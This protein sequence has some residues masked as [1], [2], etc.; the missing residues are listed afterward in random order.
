MGDEEARRLD[1]RKFVKLAG[2]G[3][4]I[5][6]AGPLLNAG[7]ARAASG[8]PVRVGVL[9]PT[10]SSY[11]SMGR[12][13]S[14]GLALGFDAARTGASAVNATITQRDVA[15][16][17][18][19]AHAAA[20]ELL[21]GG[22]DVVVAGVSA[23][24]ARQLT[25][26]FEQ[27]KT[28]LVVANVGAHVV[29]PAARSAF[30][31]HNSLLYWQASYMMG[32]AATRAGKRAF[33]ASALP[34]AGYDTIYAF[35][36]G[37]EVAGGTI[38]GEGVSHA[39]PANPGVSELVAAVKSSGA[40]VLYG[41]YSGS[42]AAEFVQAAAG[43]GARL[44]VGSLG[45]ED[46]LLPSIGDSA[47]GALS[48]ASWT[49]T[50]TTPANQAFTGAFI[51]RFRRAPDPFAALG[52][53]TAALIAAGARQATK[54]G[55]A[56]KQFTDSL[57]GTS[58]EGPRGLMAIDAATNVVTGPLTIR[59]VQKTKRGLFNVDVAKLPAVSRFPDSLSALGGPTRSG[60]VN[61]YLC[62]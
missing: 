31:L 29:T 25:S 4:G 62:A 37:F 34:D 24:V 41:L 8:I 2:A 15:R 48:C 50:R 32:I 3:A 21:N 61:E 45:I 18:G 52:Y 11:A 7:V 35:R 33:I 5:A 57:G 16:G 19:G 6:V 55:L 39:D 30:V 56:P 42:H 36:R 28:P 23:L 46:Y 27:R 60:Y 59:Q 49:A 44:A 53:D 26:L 43:S 17:Y 47:V 58:P 54:R 1:R 40:D 14:E 51:K 20:E 10:G 38:V 9:V 12:S 13:L 22:V